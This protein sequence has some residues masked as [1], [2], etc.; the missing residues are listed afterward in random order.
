MVVDD[1]L[2]RILDGGMRGEAQI[3]LRAE[4]DPTEA[5]SGVLADGAVRAGRSVGRARIGPEL[6]PAPHLLPTEERFEAAEQINAGEIAIVTQTADQ[7]LGRNVAVA[8]MP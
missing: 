7:C 8:C 1:C 6:V 2:G 4:I 3:I 5:L